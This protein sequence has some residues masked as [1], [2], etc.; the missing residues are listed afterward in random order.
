MAVNSLTMSDIPARAQAMFAANDQAK[1][2]FSTRLKQAYV[3]YALAKTQQQKLVAGLWQGD[4]LMDDFVTWMFATN[5][6][7]GRQQ[8]DLALNQGIEAV[9]DCPEPLQRLFAGLQTP[10]WLQSELLDEAVLAMQRTG[11][12]ANLVMRDL[13]LMGGYSMSGFN[14]ALVLTG[15]LTKGADKRILET[16]QWWFDCTQGMQRFS[17][18][19]KSTVHVRLIHALVRRHLSQS[20]DW[21]AQRW[22]IPICQVDMA[23]TY[24]GFCVVFLWGLRGLGLIISPRES[25]SIM[26]FWRYTC[27][28]MGVDEQW[29]VDTEKQGALLLFQTLLTQAKPD[30]T[31]LELAKSL[32]L[33]PLTRGAPSYQNWRQKWAYSKHLSI[34]RYFLGKSGMQNLGLPSNVLPWYPPLVFGI[35][36]SK[37]MLYHLLPVYK[38]YQIKQGRAEQQSNLVELGQR[39]S[40]HRS[41]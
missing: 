2:G 1:H 11:T 31:T 41:D 34:T 32:S 19:F 8:F 30:W 29:L 17:I 10:S 13:A 40:S 39:N 7:V 6:R 28:L 38:Q 21:D 9:V 15:A 23:A 26:H 16:G 18:G 22:G 3:K 4:P 20:K 25:K 27:W 35:N 36:V 5:P 14:Q 37:S 33:E 12:S 24:L